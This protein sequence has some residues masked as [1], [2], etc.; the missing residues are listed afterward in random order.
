M[1]VSITALRHYA[2]RLYANCHVSFIVML[3]VAMPSVVML[4]IIVLSVA[5]LN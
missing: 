1:R 2:E 3:N 5:M 4:S